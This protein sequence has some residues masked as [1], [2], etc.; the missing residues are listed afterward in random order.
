[1]IILKSIVI[2]LIV[3]WKFLCIHL[4]F[5]VKKILCTRAST[6]KWSIQTQVNRKIPVNCPSY[7]S[8]VSTTKV[9]CLLSCG[10]ELLWKFLVYLNLE[11]P[12]FWI[13]LWGKLYVQRVLNWVLRLFFS[14]HLILLLEQLGHVIPCAVWCIN[15]KLT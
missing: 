14:F 9:T 7:R 3:K 2:S 15:F 13:K 12:L 1:M 5:S 6:L 4:L 8:V 11:N 10:L